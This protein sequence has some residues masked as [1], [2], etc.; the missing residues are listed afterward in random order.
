MLGPEID[1]LI[2]QL[3]DSGLTPTESVNLWVDSADPDA[4]EL[5][6]PCVEA[7]IEVAG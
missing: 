2:Q 5:C 4:T 7:V 1:E 6:M 3:R